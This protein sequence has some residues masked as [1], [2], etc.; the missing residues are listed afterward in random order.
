MKGS[1]KQRGSD[2]S[3][4]KPRPIPISHLPKRS[5]LARDRALHALAAKRRDPNLSLTRAA[6]E[7]GV[8]VATV[9]K[10]FSSA[11]KVSKG[12]LHVT[13]SDR[14]T[15][16]LFVPDAHGHP[17]AV[18]TR[19]LKERRALSQYLRDVGRYQRGKRDALAPWHGKKIAGVQL[20]TD[21][22]TLASIEP[23][24]SEFSLYRTANG[25]TA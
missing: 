9:K 25:G 17:V 20:I 13:K 15:E 2:R 8:K 23:A 16:T 4:S 7:Q 22:R 19:S 5:Q 24:L 12:K 6:K 18:T 1:K 3:S 21:G 11:L 14:F 10:Y